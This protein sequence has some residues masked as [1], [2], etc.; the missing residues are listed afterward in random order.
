MRWLIDYE[1]LHGNHIVWGEEINNKK[2]TLSTDIL[3]ETRI[4][5]TIIQCAIFKFGKIRYF[6]ETCGHSTLNI[7]MTES[8]YKPH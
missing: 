1:K 6:S 7:L 2:H 3:E 4:H 8:C 5:P